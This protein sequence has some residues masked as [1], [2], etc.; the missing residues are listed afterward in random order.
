MNKVMSAEQAVRLVADGDTISISGVIGFI[1]PDAVLRALG[2]RFGLE[3][4]PAGLT[5]LNPVAVGDVYDIPGTDHLARPGMVKRVIAGSYVIGTSPRT[6]KR[7]ELV[8]RILA[9]EV[10]A[11]NF[12]IGALMGVLREI[13]AGRSGFLTE[14]G[15]GTFVDPRMGGGKLNDVTREDLVEVVQFRGREHLFYPSFPVNV[16]IIRGTTADEFGN[17][18]LEHEGML[19]G[20]LNHALAAHAS[21]GKVIAQ[22][23][24]IAI[25]GSLH[26]QMV[27][28]PGVL[29]DAIVVDERQQQ[30]T[31]MDFDP[32]VCGE[33]RSPVTDVPRLQLGTDKVI[34]RRA[35]R[36]LSENQLVI[37][38]FGVPASVTSVAMEEGVFDRLTFMVEHGAIGGVPL[39]GFQFGVSANPEILLD[40]P[41]QFDLIDGGAVDA[42]C[43]AFGEVDRWG[44]VNVSKLANLIPGC[45]GFIDIV[46]RARLLVFCGLFSAGGAEVSVEDGSVRIRREGRYCKFVSQ[47]QHLTMDGHS[48]LARGQRAIFITERAVFE[49][50]DD[51]L[52]LTEIAPGIDVERDVLSLMQFRVKVL[53][54]LRVMDAA[55]FRPE[56]V[57]I[58]LGRRL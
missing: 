55:L 50:G 44:S 7:A 9:G 3:G 22:V 56:R 4:H 24:R 58:R 10:E 23:K 16:A 53:E 1:C 6:G 13:G 11:Y 54:P 41:S 38:G 39:T 52:V 17:I 19:N 35:L 46:H 8:Q 48:L 2:D 43:L 57:G 29:V 12:P 27:R 14:V 28:V 45:G 21:G 30:G 20:V 42:A 15:L 5:V 32:R 36:E 49:L 33:V 51:G 18:T 26:P 25:A 47:L 34:C 37:L 40:T 31:G